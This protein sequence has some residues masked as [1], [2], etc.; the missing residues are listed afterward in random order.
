MRIFLPALLVWSMMS[1]DLPYAAVLKA[2]NSPDAPA[3]MI[4]VSTLMLTKTH[5]WI[6]KIKRWLMLAFLGFKITS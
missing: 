1:T 2:Q 5:R 3:P 6:N 4:R